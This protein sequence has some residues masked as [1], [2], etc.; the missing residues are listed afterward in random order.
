VVILPDPKKTETEGGLIIPDKAQRDEGRGTVV[1]VSPD[2]PNPG[3]VEG[4]R[5]MYT[6]GRVFPLEQEGHLYHVI[7]YEEI[8][9]KIG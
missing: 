2:I 5:V 9:L 3:L 7:S 1:K 8:I 4:D 6:M